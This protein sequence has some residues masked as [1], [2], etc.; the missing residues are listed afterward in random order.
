MAAP[1][2]LARPRPI[3]WKPCV[4]TKPAGSGTRRYI[5]GKPMKWPEST[6]TRAVVRQERV[7]GERERP[8]VDAKPSPPTSSYGSSRHEPAAISAASASERTPPPRT[9]AS[10]SARAVT[11]A[12]PTTATSTGRCAASGSRSTWTTLAPS[13]IRAPSR[14]VQRVSEAPNAKHEV[15]LRDQPRSDRRGEAAGDP[16]CP[17]RAGEEPVTHRG[18]GQDGADGVAERLE[19]L[20]R[21]RENCAAAGDD[22]RTAGLGDEGRRPRRWRPEKG[23]G[24][25]GERR[26][27]GTHRRPAAPGRPK[28]C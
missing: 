9:P 8:W 23:P 21:A 6:A 27:K 18:G 7:E 12:S 28:A 20:A 10:T 17:R 2:P 1:M 5:G 11:A 15:G 19:R 4:N 3:D 25:R 24:V 26:S 22:D 13:P 16:H 14:V